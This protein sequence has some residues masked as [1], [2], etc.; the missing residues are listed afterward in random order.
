MHSATRVVSFYNI[1]Q[2][3]YSDSQEENPQ[4]RESKCYLFIFDR[5]VSLT[6]LIIEQSGSTVQSAEAPVH[7][8]KVTGSAAPCILICGWR[9]RL[10][11]GLSRRMS[12]LTWWVAVIKTQSC[13]TLKWWHSL[14][15][16]RTNHILHSDPYLCYD[17]TAGKTKLVTQQWNCVQ[18]RRHLECWDRH[19]RR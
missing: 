13:I 16:S 5:P 1:I 12:V 19:W 14:S 2:F 7:L 17:N 8:S 3:F 18:F 6:S 15:G 10:A 11:S 9:N 4:V